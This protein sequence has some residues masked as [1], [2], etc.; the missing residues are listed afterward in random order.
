M[1]SPIPYPARVIG[2]MSGTS[3]DGVDAALITTDGHADVKTQDALFIP[4]SDALRRDILKLMQGQGD[5]ATVAKALTEVHI[6][7]VQELLKKQRTPVNLIGF[8]GQTI[9][10]DPKAGITLQIGD[11]QWMADTLKIP[12]VADFRTHDVK[13]GGQGAPLVP[14]YHAALAHGLP[15]PLLVVNIGGVSNVTWINEDGNRIVAFDCGP[16]NA[17]LDDWVSQHTSMRYDRNGELAA[18]GAVDEALVTQWMNDPFFSAPVPKSLDRNHFHYIM[19]VVKDMTLEN[20]AATLTCFTAATIQRAATFSPKP[21]K[22]IL[23]TGGGRHNPTLMKMLTEQL[24]SPIAPVEAA[25][26]DGDMLEAQ[27]FAYLAVRSL[28]RLPLTLPTTTGVDAPTTGGVV[29]YP[30]EK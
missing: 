28:R 2:L 15:E 13:N 9:K 7:A 17:L 27:A 21:P 23:V 5:T 16:G 20:G 19:E 24:G 6:E 8:H 30:K 1:T 26:W 3:A 14:L 29:F 18:K 12:V 10:H 25:G 22:Q 11:A 4:Y